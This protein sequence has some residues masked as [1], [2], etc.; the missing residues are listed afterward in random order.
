MVLAIAWTSALAQDIFNDQRSSW[1]RKAADTE[2]QLTETIKK[3][4]LTVRIEKDESAFQ[5]WKAVPSLPID[6]LYNQSFK[7]KTG[8]VVDFGEHLTGYFTFSVEELHRTVRCSIADQ[9]HVRRSACRTSHTIRSVSGS[10][11][12]GLVAG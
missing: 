6:S 12:Q 11:E 4:L 7:K 9:V 2:L 10:T 1:L 8:T 3:P 5:D